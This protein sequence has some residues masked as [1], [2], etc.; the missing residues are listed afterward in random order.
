MALLAAAG[1]GGGGGG[2]SNGGSAAN[3]SS[4]G[5][6]AGGG[7]AAATSGSGAGTVDPTAAVIR[8]N[9]ALGAIKNA[10]VT[11]YDAFGNALSDTVAVVDGKYTLTLKAIANLVRLDKKTYPNQ[12]SALTRLAEPAGTCGDQP[13]LPLA[14]A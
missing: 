10:N 13:C 1:G 5:T 9:A 2:G 8:G 6:G 4:G 14:G 3:G 11:A 12:A 7:A